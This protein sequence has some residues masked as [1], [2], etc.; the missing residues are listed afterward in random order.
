MI[1]LI[2][3]AVVVL[4][5]E[6]QRCYRIALDHYRGVARDSRGG[7]ALSVLI[8]HRFLHFTQFSGSQVSLR[9]C[10]RRCEKSE[11]FLLMGI[12]YKFY[13][14]NIYVVMCRC[15]VGRRAG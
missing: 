13:N 10:R 12:F 14:K 2:G 7:G 5:F 4:G 1:R 15:T 9:A 8:L 3:V 11:T 6:P